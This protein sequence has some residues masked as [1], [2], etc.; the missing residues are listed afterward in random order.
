MRTEIVPHGY[1][2]CASRGLASWVMQV[3]SG[4]L[5][6]LMGTAY[7]LCR[8]GYMFYVM[9]LWRY[10]CFLY[11]IQDLQQALP[12]KEYPLSIGARDLTEGL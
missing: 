4:V 8:V 1:Y 10:L 11:L 9:L 7:T 6:T 2:K 5:H 12:L 3:V